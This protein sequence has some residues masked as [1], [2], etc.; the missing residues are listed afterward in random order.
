MA[1]DTMVDQ[2]SGATERHS[3]LEDSDLD[4]FFRTE[5][6]RRPSAGVEAVSEPP[7]AA[8]PAESVAP[9]LRLLVQSSIDASERRARSRLDA[10][11]ERLLKATSQVAEVRNK[12]VATEHRLAALEARVTALE[13]LPSVVED[14]VT[15]HV[16]RLA[17][18]MA[19]LPADVEGVYR[20]LDAVAEVMSARTAVIGRN[21]DRLGP[22]EGAVL[23][24]RQEVR[25]AQEA[26][27]AAQATNGLSHAERLEMLERRLETM[28]RPG[29]HLERLHRALGQ[30]IADPD[31]EEVKA[32]RRPPA[33]G[34]GAATVHVADFSTSLDP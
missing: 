23:E 5:N 6:Q 25:R 20:E 18:Q 8:P 34:A 7:T 22:L 31:W 28:E 15:C 12:M 33:Q 19:G 30:I 17:A 3:A 16:D 24:L 2:P 4:E 10:M 21:L 13:A 14:L 29:A 27:E 26:A 11:D 1:R 9:E 32:G